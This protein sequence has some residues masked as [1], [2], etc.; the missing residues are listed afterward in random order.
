MDTKNLLKHSLL[1]TKR[2]LCIAQSDIGKL[3]H[4]R[5]LMVQS[6]VLRNDV[7]YRVDLFSSVPYNTQV[8]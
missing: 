4:E 3:A 5:S 2:S 8:E 7:S 6:Q 1:T